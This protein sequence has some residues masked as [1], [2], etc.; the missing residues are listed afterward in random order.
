ML[1]LLLEQDPHGRGYLWIEDRQIANADVDDWRVRAYS[2][3]SPHTEHIHWESRQSRE[4]IDAEWPMPHLDALLRELGLMEDDVTP[5]DIKK[6]AAAVQQAVLFDKVIPDYSQPEEGRRKLSLATWVGYSD[7]RR[8]A[9]LTA[10]AGELDEGDLAERLSA[11][12][13]D[14]V[15]AEELLEALRGLFAPTAPEE[16]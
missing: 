12:M 3:D 15:T 1:H 5:E 10:L 2:G 14:A 8:N 16:N 11:R 6:I 13:G 9:I 7:H 4:H